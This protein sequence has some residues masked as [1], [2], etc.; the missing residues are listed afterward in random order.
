MCGIAGFW[1]VNSNEEESKLSL[2]KMAGALK[3]RGPD[4]IGYWHDNSD[5]IYF[6]HTRLSIIDLSQ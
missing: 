5:S 4:H 1:S 2:K 3:H 6:S